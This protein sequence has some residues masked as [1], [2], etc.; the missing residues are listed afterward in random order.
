MRKFLLS[1]LILLGCTLSVSAQTVTGTVTLTATASDITAAVGDT[2]C[3][4]ASVQFFN[5]STALGAPI[6]SPTSGNDYVL[7]LNTRTMANGTYT[8][9]A[10]ATDKAG[11]G[12]SAATLCDGSKPNVGTSAPLTMVVNN[13]APDTN[14]PSVTVIVIVTVP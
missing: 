11:V 5:G 8:I 13:A 12:T 3:G 14:A 9:T 6:T 4:V 1:V 10:K 2:E 7:S